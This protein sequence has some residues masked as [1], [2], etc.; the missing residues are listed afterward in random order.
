VGGWVN[1]V[2]LSLGGRGFS[3]EHRLRVS[4]ARGRDRSAHVQAGLIWVGIAAGFVALVVPGILMLRDY[5][6]WRA[7][8]RLGPGSA[9]VVGP[10]VLWAAIGLAIWVLTPLWVLAIL[11][12]MIG[13]PPTLLVA[14][15]G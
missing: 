2:G 13:L 11:V 5:R 9:A 4:G 6:D 3:L 1:R 12:V 10:L 8:V 15:R 14:T 7:H